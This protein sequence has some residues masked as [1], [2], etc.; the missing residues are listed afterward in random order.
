LTWRTSPFDSSNP[1]S[2]TSGANAS[3]T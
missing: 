1:G 2:S 3:V